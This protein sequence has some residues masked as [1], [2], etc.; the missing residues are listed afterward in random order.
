LAEFTEFRGGKLDQ[1][2]K[3]RDKLPGL[4]SRLERL[5]SELRPALENY[6]PSLHE[7][8][9][10]LLSRV[11]SAAQFYERCH[12]K[13]LGGIASE[14]E[15]DSHNL[16]SACLNQFL[17]VVCVTWF[18]GTYKRVAAGSWKGPF[19]RFAEAAVAPFASAIN[20]NAGRFL[21]SPDWPNLA[22]RIASREIQNHEFL[23]P[24]SDERP[25]VKYKSHQR[26]IRGSP[27]QRK[28]N[29]K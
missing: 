14:G 13:T 26:V 9:Q 1:I 23:A 3:L 27:R 7:D 24:P 21:I 19:G 28:S 29:G 17:V 11:R 10:K 6:G 18:R 16:A 2:I 8:A 25:V 4:V 12:E 15:H 22:E 20:T 5:V